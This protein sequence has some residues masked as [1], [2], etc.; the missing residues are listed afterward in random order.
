MWKSFC[1]G[2]NDWQQGFHGIGE[3]FLKTGGLE[4]VDEWMDGWKEGN[5]SYKGR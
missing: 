4:R 3:V 2:F 5:G 1:G